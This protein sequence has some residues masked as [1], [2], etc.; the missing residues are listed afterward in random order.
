MSHTLMMQWSTWQRSSLALRC[1]RHKAQQQF[2][3]SV[4]IVTMF[5]FAVCMQVWLICLCMPI[6]RVN[7]LHDV[8]LS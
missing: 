6:A 3:Q 1:Y 2:V 5:V 7:G 8:V 4:S